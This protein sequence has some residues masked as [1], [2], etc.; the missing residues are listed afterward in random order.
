MGED[1]RALQNV[2]LTMQGALELLG[3]T[4]PGNDAGAVE[5]AARAALLAR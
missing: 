4:T 5:A 1:S 2:R 3:A